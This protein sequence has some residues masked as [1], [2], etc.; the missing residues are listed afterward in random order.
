MV[1]FALFFL[2]LRP[3]FAAKNDINYETAHLERRLTAIKTTEKI[4]IDGRLDEPAW[5]KAPAADHFVQREPEEGEPASESTEIR[6]LYDDDNLYFAISAKDSQAGRIIINEL[7]KDFNTDS[8]DSVEII[9][10]TFHDGRNAYRFATSPA[11]AKWDAQ[12][13]GEGAKT[14]RIGTASGT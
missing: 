9:L 10:D 12:M 11:G 1:R 13:V 8:G 3:G 5:A 4:G 6:V 7:R 2:M 14:T